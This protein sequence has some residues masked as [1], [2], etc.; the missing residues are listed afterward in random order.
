MRHVGSNINFVEKKIFSTFYVY[1]NLDI[2][3]RKTMASRIHSTEKKLL[4][5]SKIG[6][7]ELG[8]SLT[9]SS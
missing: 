3:R 5:T 4:S 9:V 6:V 8:L 1:Q 2:H 7:G